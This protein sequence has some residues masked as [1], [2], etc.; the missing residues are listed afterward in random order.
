MNAPASALPLDFHRYRDAARERG[1]N[2]SKLE[3]EKKKRDKDS[4]PGRKLID[5]LF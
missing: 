4:W 2:F 5:Q 1:R 3:S